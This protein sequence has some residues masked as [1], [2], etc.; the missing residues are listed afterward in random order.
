MPLPGR[1]KWIPYL[2]QSAWSIRW[3]SGFLKSSW[4][5]LWSTYWTARS[6]LTRGTSSCSNC[7]S[8]IVPVAS[9]RRVWSIRRAIGSP[10]SRSP[11]TRCS[12]SICR[13]RF[14]ATPPCSS[15]N[16]LPSCGRR[17]VLVQVEQVGRVVAVLELLEPRVLVL[18]EGGAHPVLP[19]GGK[20]V[21][22]RPSGQGR[23]HRA[24]Q[25][26]R[27]VHVRVPSAGLVRRG[28]DVQHERCLTFAICR[29]VVRDA[30][31]RPTEVLHVDLRARGRRRLVVARRRLD[32]GV[33]ELPQVAG[34]EVRLRPVG[35][36][37]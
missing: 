17:H 2:R 6:T 1:E 4:M 25:A 7:I 32:R 9:W 14:S 21:D 16:P 3:S 29:L 10:G 19:L 24:I 37:G 8:D 15:P 11:S 35:V 31:D 33:V 22:V 36:E 28:H 30:G 20:E 34:L 5:T 13:V 23:L 27:P 12:R 18:A 26:L